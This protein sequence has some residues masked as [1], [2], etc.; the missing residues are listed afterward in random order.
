MIPGSLDQYKDE[1]NRLNGELALS[2]KQRELWRHEL[3]SK[4]GVEDTLREEVAQAERV[5]FS[6]IYPNVWWTRH[7]APL[8]GFSWRQCDCR[9]QT[10]TIG[11]NCWTH[12]LTSARNEFRRKLS[13]RN[14]DSQ[15]GDRQARELEKLNQLLVQERKDNFKRLAT[16][17]PTEGI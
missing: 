17:T 14:Y 2:E 5:Q 1:C 13:L 3:T 16:G 4:Q 15:L 6:S 8:R 12:T 11:A 9:A 10:V 7:S